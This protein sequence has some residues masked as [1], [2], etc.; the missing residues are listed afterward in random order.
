MTTKARRLLY[1]EP[2]ISVD[3][4]LRRA[5]RRHRGIPDWGGWQAY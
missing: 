4:G 3:E 5:V 2:P 1:W